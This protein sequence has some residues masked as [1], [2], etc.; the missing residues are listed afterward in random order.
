[1]SAANV[2]PEVPVELVEPM[3]SDTLIYTS[4]AGETLHVRMDGQAEVRPGDEVEIGFQPD[5][6][7]LFDP[8]TEL[9]L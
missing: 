5:R 7:S 9:R 6:A 2:D 8:D 4:L 1:M 3:G